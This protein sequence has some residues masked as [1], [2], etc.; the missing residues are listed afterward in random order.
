MTW[1]L[2]SHIEN[3]TNLPVSIWVE[4]MWSHKKMR[5]SYENKKNFPKIARKPSNHILFFLFSYD[6]IWLGTKDT[7]WSSWYGLKSCMY[8]MLEYFVHTDAT[9]PIPYQLDQLTVLVWC[10]ILVFHF[11]SYS[12]YLQLTILRYVDV[13]FSRISL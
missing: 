2:R 10:N 5:Q 11:A 9:F 8:T 13:F 3:R 6:F 1:E 4:A 12:I 7:A